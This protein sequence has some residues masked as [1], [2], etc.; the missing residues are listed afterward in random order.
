M[1]KYTLIRPK[2]IYC[3][4]K[5][6]IQP[7][8]IV[9]VGGERIVEVGSERSLRNGILKQ[10]DPESLQQIDLPGHYL[11]PGLCNTHVHLSFSATPDTLADCL[12]ESEMIQGIRAAVNAGILL[13]SG[14]TTVRDAG[15][16]DSLI[17]I[18]Q[19]AD[20]GFM[21]L[22][23]LIFCGAPVTVTRGHCYFLGG[24]ADGP[25]A[26]R[27][28]VRRRKTMGASALKIM[29]SGG[30]L[31]PGTKPEQ[32][33]YS[34]EELDAAVEEA[35]NLGMPTL[36]HCLSPQSILRAARAG[37]G[38]IDHCGFLIRDD[39]GRLARSYDEEVARELRDSGCFFTMSLGLANRL[40]A[41]RRKQNRSEAE[42]FQ[43]EQERLRLEIFA[44]LVDLGIKPVVGTDT[45]VP[46]TSFDETFLELLYMTKAGLSAEDAIEAATRSAVRAMGLDDTIGRI[47]PGC[48]ADLI[49]VPGDPVKDI[50]RLSQ[51]DWVMAHGEIVA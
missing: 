40:E 19:L 35:G 14:V 49:A 50:S 15:S 10:V 31:T 32:P 16:R 7:G 33:S 17:S 22:P 43:L 21:E 1:E 41:I 38:C 39:R 12:S 24:E 48:A 34:Q 28:A 44:R 18:S 6:S 13:R 47:A 11:M 26:V 9:L 5:R 30:N 23:K 51:V 46:N 25:E 27:A 36:A 37:I 3:P 2:A 42:E 8:T 29:A 4:D 45:G 20:K